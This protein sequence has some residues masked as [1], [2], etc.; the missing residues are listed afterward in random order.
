MKIEIDVKFNIGDKVLVKTPHS[1]S[2][3]KPTPFIALIGG[4]VIIKNKKSTTVRYTL[5]PLTLKD[6]LN[7]SISDWKRK[8]R[9]GVNELEKVE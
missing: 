8:K 3:Y 1:G 7:T 9:Y 2:Y 5:E 6:G 4:Y